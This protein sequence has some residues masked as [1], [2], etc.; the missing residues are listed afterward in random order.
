MGLNK[1]RIDS[2]EVIICSYDKDSIKVN[3]ILIELVVLYW[4]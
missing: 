4:G 1:R 3:L 2:N